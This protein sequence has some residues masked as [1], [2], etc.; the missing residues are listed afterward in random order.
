M[1]KYDNVLN[2]H[3]NLLK[4]FAKVAE[5]NVLHSSDMEGDS[6]PW[7]V[8]AG[9]C[10]DRTELG[11]SLDLHVNKTDNDIN[12]AQWSRGMILALGA[13]GPGFK[14]RLSPTF[15]SKTIKT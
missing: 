4:Q 7:R 13:R 3:K 1:T 15:L 12:T 2:S 9:R 5:K 6:T 8:K 14:S 11:Q 10:R